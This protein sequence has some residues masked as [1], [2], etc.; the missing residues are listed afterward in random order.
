M[1]TTFRMEFLPTMDLVMKIEL[2]GGLVT[3]CDAPMIHFQCLVFTADEFM[4]M[5]KP[6]KRTLLKLQRDAGGATYSHRVA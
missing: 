3:P 4:A 1:L 2:G 5:P 6:P